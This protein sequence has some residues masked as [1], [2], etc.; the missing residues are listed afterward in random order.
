MTN[1]EAIM[2][3]GWWRAAT[4][5]NSINVNPRG[6]CM[7]I[8]HLSFKKPMKKTTPQLYP[9]EV[10]SQRK[11]TATKAKKSGTAAAEPYACQRNHDKDQPPG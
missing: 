1:N 10:A 8:L 11:K 2:N 7:T 6:L 3:D 9:T 5:N 4:T